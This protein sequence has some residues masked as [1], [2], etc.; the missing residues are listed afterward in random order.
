MKTFWLQLRNLWHQRHFLQIPKII[1]IRLG[2]EI[3]LVYLM[4]ERPL[5]VPAPEIR[6]DNTAYTVAVLGPSDMSSVS[7][8]TNVPTETLHQWLEDRQE[9]YGIKL[10]NEVVAVTWCDFTGCRSRFYSTSLPPQSAY[11]RAL[12]TKKS[13]RGRNLATVLRHRYSRSLTARGYTRFYSLTVADNRASLKVKRKL[14]ARIAKII[15]YIRLFRKYQVR[16]VLWSAG[17]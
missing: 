10:K 6:G 17:S 2:T 13:F 4:V 3:H 8:I 15:L 7:R 14:N 11:L 5:S 1:L 12:H 9:C 16:F